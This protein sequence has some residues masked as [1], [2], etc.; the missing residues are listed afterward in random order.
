M[1]NMMN[2]EE[3]DK[4]YLTYQLKQEERK[5]LNSQR[6]LYKKRVKD[7]QLIDIGYYKVVST[8]RRPDYLFIP[9]WTL[10]PTQLPDTETGYLEEVFAKKAYYP[11]WL[12][13]NKN[14]ELVNVSIFESLKEN[15]VNCNE[16]VGFTNIALGWSWYYQDFE[17]ITKEFY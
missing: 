3:Y 12:G 7:N 11:G 17:N 9:G 4:Q 16:V 5:Q 6:K 1:T 10:H 8:N 15:Y 14:G 13:K 2:E